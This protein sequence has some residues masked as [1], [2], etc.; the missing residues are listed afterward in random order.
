[1]STAPYDQSKLLWNARPAPRTTPR[2]PKSLWRLTKDGHVMT[3]GLRYHGEYVVSAA[4][5][6]DLSVPDP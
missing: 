4:P 2:E 6:V 3:A 1:M 5:L